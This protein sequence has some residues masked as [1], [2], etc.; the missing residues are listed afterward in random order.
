MNE[1]EILTVAYPEGLPDWSR[2][3]EVP[4]PLK[5]PDGIIYHFLG[6]AVV[7]GGSIL[8]GGLCQLLIKHGG[9]QIL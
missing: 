9:V 3:G 7:I 4:N 2:E 6:P 5:A 8:E 1:S